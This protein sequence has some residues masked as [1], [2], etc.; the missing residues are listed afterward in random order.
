MTEV[1]ECTHYLRGTYDDPPEYCDLDAVPGTDPPR[2]S[3]HRE[4][5]EWGGDEDTHDY[6]D[7]G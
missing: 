3:H 2:C 4:D 6:Y 5:D 1:A 7:E